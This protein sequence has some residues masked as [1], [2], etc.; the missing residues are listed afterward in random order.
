MAQSDPAETISLITKRGHILREVGASGMGKREL[1]EQLLV[2]RS[3]VDRGIRELESAGLLARSAEGYRRT[4]LGELLLTEYEQF[5]SQTG[6]LLEGR[7]LLAD[8]P[9]EFELDPVV[10]EDA[11]IVT[12]SR[13]APH[14]PISA[15]CSLYRESRWTQTVVPAVFPQ[16]LAQWVQLCEKVMIRADIVVTEPVVSTLVASHADQLQHLIEESR[17]SLHQIDTEI[18]YGL[19]VAETE[20]TATAGVVVMDDRGSG[21]AFIQTDAAEAVTWVRERINDQ[22]MQSTPLASLPQ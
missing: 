8:L 16:L 1:V 2:S 15:F 3:T 14:Q 21:R 12:A 19:V 22:L 10:F 20:S 4:L 18:N 11:T 17:F 13:H 7:E 9:P 6:S 5:A